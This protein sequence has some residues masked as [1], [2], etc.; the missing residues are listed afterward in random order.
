MTG[1]INLLYGISK[2]QHPEPAGST[3]D[4]INNT[5][6]FPSRAP[7]ASRSS[8]SST[9]LLV[10]VSLLVVACMRTGI[11]L[12]VGSWSDALLGVAC[13]H[14]DRI[15][16]VRMMHTVGHAYYN[17]TGTYTGIIA[18]CSRTRVCSSTRVLSAR[19][20]PAYICSVR[21]DS[22]FSRCTSSFVC[23]KPRHF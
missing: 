3:R 17:T 2:A 6:V 20:R 9:R 13:R 19:R 12:L 18:P 1:S 16:G 8:G 23:T 15:H 10:F 21:A 7:K 14:A 22:P 4:I 11:V 5:A